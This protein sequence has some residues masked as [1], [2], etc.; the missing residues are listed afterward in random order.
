MKEALGGNVRL[1]VSGAA[2]LAPFLAE[3]LRVFFNCP[4]AQGYGMTETSAVCTIS[5]PDDDNIGHVGPAMPHCE[6]KLQDV[7]EMKYFHTDKLPDGRATPRGEIMVRGA[8]IFKEYYKLP[9]KTAEVIEPDGWM[10]TGDIGRIN[11]NGTLSIIDRKKNIFKLGQGEYVAIEMVEGEY[12]KNGFVGQLWAYGNSFENQLVAV[13]VPSFDELAGWASHNG[14]GS[15]PHPT[16]TEKVIAHYAK[17][18]ASKK[19]KDFMW[20]EMKKMEGKLKGFEKI[21][22][23]HLEKEIDGMRQ[24]FTVENNCL[25]PTFKLKRPMLKDRYE[26]EIEAMYKTCR[27]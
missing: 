1:F 12:T 27:R 4:V 6:I 18:V 23:I 10:H 17:L 16:E 22:A 5:S 8:H 13:V 11:P 7:E 3:F 9:E 25:T 21:R 14:F 15:P 19:V 20:A 24:G 26:A 2:P